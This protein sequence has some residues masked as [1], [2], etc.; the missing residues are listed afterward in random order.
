LIFIG[1]FIQ[2]F[3]EAQG[4]AAPVFKFIDEVENN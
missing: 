2:S 1:P 4:A 3:S